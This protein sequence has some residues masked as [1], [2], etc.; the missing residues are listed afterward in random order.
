MVAE[1]LARQ[2][3]PRGR[4]GAARGPL[5]RL[6]EPDAGVGLDAQRHVL[7]R[8]APFAGLALEDDQVDVVIEALD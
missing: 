6:R 4:Y 8:V 1:L 2:G 3:A 5:S 7:P